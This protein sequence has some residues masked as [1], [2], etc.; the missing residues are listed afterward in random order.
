M[1]LFIALATATAGSEGGHLSSA[2]AEIAIAAVIGIAIGGLGGR[3]LLLADRRGLASRLSRQI[4]VLA[5][6]LSG[7]FASVAL[8][9]NG[10]VAAFV[11][12]LAFGGVTRHVEEPSELFSEVGGILLSVVVW[13]V[14]GVSFVELHPRHGMGTFGRSCT[15]SSASPSSG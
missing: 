15:R 8:G 7:Y 5:L 9:G 3:L 6:A 2:L 12:G 13:T 10:F 1:L 11:A 4:A 14:F